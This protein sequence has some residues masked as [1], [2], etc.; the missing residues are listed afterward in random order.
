MAV[1][2]GNNR[3]NQAAPIVVAFY[4]AENLGAFGE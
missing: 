3:E 4:K 1:C 2:E